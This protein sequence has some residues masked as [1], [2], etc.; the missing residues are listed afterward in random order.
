MKIKVTI[1]KEIEVNDELFKQY[2]G[3]VSVENKDALILAILES[4]KADRIETIRSANGGRFLG[5][6][7]F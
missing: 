3:Y 4:T 6:L 7:G 1:T 5:L 2:G